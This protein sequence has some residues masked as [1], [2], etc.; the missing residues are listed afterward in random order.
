M[1]QWLGLHAF[2]SQGAGSIPG[3]GTK[4]HMPFSLKKKKNVGIIVIPICRQEN[5]G[6]EM[7]Y[8]PWSPTEITHL[9]RDETRIQINAVF[10]T[11]W[12]KARVGWFE[13]IALK[14]VYYHMWNR[15]PVQV[16]CMRQGPQ[17]WGTGDKVLKVTLRD[18]M[19][20]WEGG[21]GWGTHVQPW[22]IHVNVWQN[23]LQYL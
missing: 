6:I 18:G 8:C 2:T 12:E 16:R 3:Q 20:R 11:L 13:R 17:G 5:W 19:G 10:W 9:A 15:S 22:L 4:I 23:P 21:L 14:H 7:F 1:V